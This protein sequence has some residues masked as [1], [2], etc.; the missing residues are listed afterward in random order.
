MEHSARRRP[1]AC[2]HLAYDGA[3]VL[4][5]LIS[6][7]P[8]VVL[9]NQTEPPPAWPA[10]WLGS[11]RS[12]RSRFPG[13]GHPDEIFFTKRGPQLETGGRAVEGM[14]EDGD[15]QRGDAGDAVDILLARR[16]ESG[17][18]ADALSSEV[19]DRVERSEI[20]LFSSKPEEMTAAVLTAGWEAWGPPPPPSPA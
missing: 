15:A 16:V 3:S 17:C 4:N 13:N 18:D 14:G 10:K 6:R 19:L 8:S 1:R 5:S 12:S 20:H 9:K 2:P 11:W 7:F